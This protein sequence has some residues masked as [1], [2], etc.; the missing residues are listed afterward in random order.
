MN[1]N[2]RYLTVVTERKFLLIN[3]LK[4]WENRGFVALKYM[5]GVDIW[6]TNFSLNTAHSANGKP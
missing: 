2:L 3:I 4:C 6:I 5:L 1:H